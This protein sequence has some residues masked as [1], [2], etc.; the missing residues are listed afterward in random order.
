VIGLGGDGLS[1]SGNAS[2]MKKAR[3]GRG[4]GSITFN[5][6]K[7]LYVASIVSGR[8]KN[9]VLR[10]RF[11]YAKN[12]SDVIEKL[13][14]LQN[15]D[16]LYQVYA[17]SD[18]TVRSYL[19]SWLNNN[20][21]LRVREGTYRLYKGYVENKLISDHIFSGIKLRWLTAADVRALYA[22]LGEK[23]ASAS[24]QRKLHILLKSALKQAVKDG[25]LS[26]NVC[27][28]VD[29]PR[30]PKR[31]MRCLDER[32]SATLLKALNGNPLRALYVLALTS[33]LR[34]GELL[35]LQR[36]DVNLRE[37]RLL[38]R[39][40][41]DEKTQTT[42]EPKSERSRRTVELPGIAVRA[43]REHLRRSLA[44]GETSP[45]WVFCDKK[46][47]P[48]RGSHIVRDSFSEVL[49]QAGLPRIR[50]HD[51][52]HTAATLM[53]LKGISIMAVSKMLGHSSVAFTLQTYGHVLP[54]M[55]KEAVA[56]MDELFA[57]VRAR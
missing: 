1:R 44:R 16:P 28:A 29:A 15:P 31:E 43:L 26:R 51:L 49:D 39:R 14:R 45:I 2:Q 17:Q 57:T 37:G 24:L 34:L 13:K 52:R 40:T 21:R 41:F 50:F 19:Q 9:G 3:R 30:V 48:L 23:G 55:E 36:S 18:F 32:Q 47:R 56:K 54:S 33:G 38:I 6:A 27:D 42:K 25:I 35:G 11:V 8:D 46:G 53:L 20:A 12:K 22:R 5:A 7:G 10:R 4:E